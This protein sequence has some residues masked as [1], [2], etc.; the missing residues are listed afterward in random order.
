MRKIYYWIAGG[1]AV[2]I[3]ITTIYLAVIGSIYDSVN[4]KVTDYMFSFKDYEEL[5]AVNTPLLTR[6]VSK[7]FMQEST[8]LSEEVLESRYYKYRNA[9]TRV[10]DFKKVKKGVYIFGLDN[11]YLE[12]D[13][14]YMIVFTN[15]LYFEDW[16]FKVVEDV[17]VYGVFD[18]NY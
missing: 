10:I 16:R 5:V 3:L 6:L 18:I 17:Q 8:V 11:M 9:E 2:I 14:K 13:R 15:N 4:E 12:Y 1:L 7:E